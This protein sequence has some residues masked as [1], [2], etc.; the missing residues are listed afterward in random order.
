MEDKLISAGL[1]KSQALAYALLIERGEIS[2]PE[3]AAKLK[4]SRTNAYKLLDKLAE[5]GLAQKSD[6][7]KTSYIANNPMALTTLASDL[8]AQAH[9]RENAVSDVMKSLLG[10]YYENNEQP[11]IKITSGRTD[12]ANAFHAQISLH[13]DIYFIHSKADVTTMGFDVLHEIR[14]KPSRHN[15]KRFGIMSD[16]VNGPI[17][18]DN[19]KRTNLTPTWVKAEDYNMPV[20]W[21][22]TKSSLLI[23]LYGAEPHAISISNPIIASAF[24]QIWHILD[25]SLR[26]M[27]YYKS[28]PRSADS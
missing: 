20:E 10:K 24:L 12:V 21:S 27:P 13:E 15:L 17:N 6:D 26:M 14:T 7:K 1:S 19:Y 5:M 25:S 8:R 22:V 4:L 11:D 28:L 16:K 23:I 3:A 18:Y 9:A 2:P